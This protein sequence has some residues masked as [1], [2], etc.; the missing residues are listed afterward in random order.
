MEIKYED[1]DNFTPETFNASLTGLVLL[2]RSGELL[3]AQVVA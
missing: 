1:A 3:K 2:P